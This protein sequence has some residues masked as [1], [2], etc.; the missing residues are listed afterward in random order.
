MIDRSKE[1]RA[2]SLR[3][4]Y[5]HAEHHIGTFPLE[6]HGDVLAMVSSA[7]PSFEGNC[8][9]HAYIDWE[10]KVDAEFDNYDLSEQQMIFAASIALTNDALA[11]WKHLYRRNKVPQT[12]YAFKIHFRDAYIPSFFVDHLLNKLEK[13]K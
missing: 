9:P 4:G 8:D 3:H 6:V 12:W 5:L 13:L 2:G 10:L 7:L 11:E 1:T